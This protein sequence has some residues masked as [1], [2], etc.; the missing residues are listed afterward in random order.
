MIAGTRYGMGGAMGN[1]GDSYTIRGTIKNTSEGRT[2]DYHLLLNGSEISSGSVEFGGSASVI[3]AN[4]T[5]HGDIS[6]IVRVG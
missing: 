1:E 3:S 6:Y 2:V 4:G 5:L